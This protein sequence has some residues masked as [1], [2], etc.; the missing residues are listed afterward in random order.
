MQ[1]F[2]VTHIYGNVSHVSAICT[3]SAREEYQIAG[4]QVRFRYCFTHFGLSKQMYEADSRRIFEDM[5][6]K[7]RAIKYSCSGCRCSEFI[8][9]SHILF[10][11]VN[12]SSSC[13]YRCRFYRSRW[14]NSKNC[15]YTQSCAQAD[16]Y[17]LLNPMLSIH[18]V[19]TSK[20]FCFCDEPSISDLKPTIF[21]LIGAN[22]WAA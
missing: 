18:V 19:I 20:Q 11:E 9:C 10:T 21:W 16:Y 13:A 12:D 4:S 17:G 3:A 6:H 8:R 22:P 1:N 14:C 7:G 5:L 15:S 2:V